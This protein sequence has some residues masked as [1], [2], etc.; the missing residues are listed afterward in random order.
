MRHLQASIFWIFTF[1]FSD[2]TDLSG[3]SSSS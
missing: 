1:S 3:E 2:T